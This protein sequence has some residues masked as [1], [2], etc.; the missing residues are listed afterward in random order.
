[1]EDCVNEDDIKMDLK[2][3]NF[4]FTLKSSTVTKG[5]KVGLFYILMKFVA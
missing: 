5:T 2:E 4:D 3:T 1:M